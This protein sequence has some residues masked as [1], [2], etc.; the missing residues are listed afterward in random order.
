LNQQIKED[1]MYTT[2]GSVRGCCGHKHRTIDAAHSC[3]ERDQ[4]ACKKQGGYSDRYI[5]HCDG[6]E[7]TCDEIAEI[8]NL[9]M[10]SD[11]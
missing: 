11:Y 3:L 8:D 7:L 5:E 10:K 9:D 4:N 2:R 1:I 6:K